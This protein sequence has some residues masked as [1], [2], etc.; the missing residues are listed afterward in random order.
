MGEVA[1]AGRTIVFVSHQMNQI[2]RLCEKVIWM[3][4]GTIR[5]AGPTAEVVG[6]YESALLSGEASEH[7]RRDSP[8][9]KA[10]FLRWEILE[11]R[12]AQPNVFNRPGPLE[13]PFM[14][15]VKL[16]IPRP[17]HRIGLYHA[18]LPLLWVTPLHPS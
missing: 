9:A 2:R 7:V 4:G 17:H 14:V 3:D 11:P 1:H 16:P 15:D 10:Q 18:D 12:A 8:Q 6:A 5:Q 13:L